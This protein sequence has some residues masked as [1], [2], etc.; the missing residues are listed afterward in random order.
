[1]HDE[2]GAAYDTTYGRMGGLLGLELRLTN[3]L[4]QNILLYGYVSPPV[5]ILQD[6]LTPPV[7]QPGVPKLQ[8]A[9]AHTATPTA[10]R[11]C[12]AT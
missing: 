6:S 5:D 11:P 2:M 4:A 3:N 10:R 8:A 9:R 1:M 7:E 12:I